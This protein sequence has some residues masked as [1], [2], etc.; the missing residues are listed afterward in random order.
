MERMKV[1]RRNLLKIAGA[2]GVLLMAGGGGVAVAGSKMSEKTAST[3]IQ[4]AARTGKQG[5]ELLP[6]VCGMCAARCGLIAYVEGGRVQKLEGNFY[7]SHSLGR[8]CARGSAA[9]KLLYD[10]DRLKSPMRHLGTR[11]GLDPI[12]WDQAYQD[13]SAKLISIRNRY[14]PESLAWM[15]RSPELTDGW[16][17]HFMR[18]WGSP[19]VFSDATTGHSSRTLACKHTLGAV[20]ISDLRNS[21]YILVF[22]RNFA[23]SIFTADIEALMEAKEKG[24]HIVV[25]DPRMTSTAAQAHEWVPIRPGGDGALLLAMM[26]VIVSDSLYDAAFVSSNTIGFEQ[27]RSFL[28]DKTPSWAASR[29]DVAPET[30]VRLAREFAAAKPACGV[31]PSWHAAWGA[32]YDNSVQTARAALVLNALVGSYGAKGGLLM[33][34]DSP[35][36]DFAFPTTPP[37]VA[38]RVDGAGAADYPLAD[39]SDGIIQTL[40]DIILSQKPYPIKALVVNHLNPMRSLPNTAK[41]AEAL[42]KL[43]LLVVI[44]VQSSETAEMAHYVLPE[45]TFLERTDPLVVSNR[46]YP[47]VALREPIVDPLYDTKPAHQIIPELAKRVGLGQYFDFTVE[48]VIRASL[49]PTGVSLEELRKKGVWR[50]TD[51]VSYGVKSFP[52][53]SGKIKIYV[54]D[55]E[56][57]GFDPLP[58]WQP[59]LV[60]PESGKSFR[61]LHGKKAAHTGTTTQNNG[62]LHNLSPENELWINKRRAATLGISDGDEVEVHSDVGQI[63]VKAKVTEGIHP[64]AVFLAHGYGRDAELQKLSRGKGANDSAL[65]IDRV[66]PMSGGAAMEET[67]VHVKRAV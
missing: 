18:A 20:P 2:T 16:D 65:I 14:G 10:P 55:F 25:V 19:N 49:K 50:A 52:T 57:A 41:V 17:A 36:G 46:F 42:K 45:S 31:D 5:P 51:T 12:S 9:I 27:L 60:A 48:D 40:P 15:R 33:P 4:P 47:E 21:K 8:I 24:A 6:T 22:G 54:K 35:I 64:E 63:R 53:P 1:S 66:E 29:A 32:M 7:H 37:L 38:S 26:N 23:E 58:N 44:D 67:I 28:A 56:E 13:I 11:G 30:I 62:Y 61:L 39:P 34:V 43:E 3:S 59:P